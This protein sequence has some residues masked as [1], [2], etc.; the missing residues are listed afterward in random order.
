MVAAQFIILSCW[1]VFLLYWLV[2]AWSVKPTQEVKP[3]IGKFRWVIIGIAVVLILLRS[4]GVPL[5]FLSISLL[6][7]SPLISVTSVVLVLIGLL[8]A[9]MARSTLAGNWSKDIE[10]KQGHELVT[11]GL[12]SYVRH[13][14]YTGVLLMGIGSVL[15]VGTIGVLLLFLWMLFYFWYKLTQEEK[16]LSE[17]FPKTYPRYKKRVKA[18]IPYIL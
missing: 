17:H 10:L 6:P 11:T 7:H 14:I 2:T 13:P 8:I 5:P 3:G 4:F 9:I 15:F 12:Y 18:L 16:L 1:I